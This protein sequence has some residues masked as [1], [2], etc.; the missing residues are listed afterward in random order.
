MKGAEG[1][2]CDDVTTI[3][4]AARTSVHA[5]VVPRRGGSESRAIDPWW[6]MYSTTTRAPTR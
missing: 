4:S 3:V 2:A 1:C 6:F 5:V